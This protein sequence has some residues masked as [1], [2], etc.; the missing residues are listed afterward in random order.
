MN[1]DMPVV[2]LTIGALA[3][4]LIAVVIA[5]G[6]PGTLW[7][8]AALAVEQCEAQLPRNTHCVVTAVPE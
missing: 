8:D 3:G 7:N 5:S 6:V 4:A 1:D 2:W